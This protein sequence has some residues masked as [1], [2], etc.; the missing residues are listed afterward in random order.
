LDLRGFGQSSKPTNG[1]EKKTMAQ[2]IHARKIMISHATQNE[3]A[4]MLFASSTIWLQNS[5][6][7]QVEADSQV[8]LFQ[9]T[10]NR[11]SNAVRE[12]NTERWILFPERATGFR[13]IF[14]RHRR[15]ANE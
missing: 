5:F 14:G 10:H 7:K 12:A 1:Y 2:D 8:A 11:H 13:R 6:L 15:G 4:W 9:R 3:S